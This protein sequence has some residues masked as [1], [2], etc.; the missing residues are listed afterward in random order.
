[1]T[2]ALGLAA[3]V[4]IG[5][6][7]GASAVAVISATDN[8]TDGVSNRPGVFVMRVVDGDTLVVAPGDR[9]RL[10]GI[11]T[12]ESGDCGY[13]RATDA[14]RR[15]VES[16]MVTLGNP[17]TVQDEDKYGRLLRYVD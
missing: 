2:L 8:E 12:P 10:I 6:V 1:M 17:A 13:Q 3:K 15:L 7:A 5:A 4:A 9:V 16:R 11:D 14:L